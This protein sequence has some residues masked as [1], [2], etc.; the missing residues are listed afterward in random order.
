[1]NFLTAA[2]TRSSAA[3]L[4]NSGGG[5][6]RPSRA[7]VTRR[8]FLR[9]RSDP[10]ISRDNNVT[11]SLS[12][13][14]FC[15]KGSDVRKPKNLVPSALENSAGAIPATPSSGD[16]N[17]R[18]AVVGWSATTL[19]LAVGNRVLQKLALVP[20]KNYPFFL[21]QVNGIVYVGVYFSVLLMRYR[22]GLTTGEMLAIPKWPFVAIGVLE[23]FSVVS[24]MYAG[25]MLPGPAIPLLYQTFL[26]WQLVFSS[27]LLERR[28]SLNQII[29]CLFVGAG[30]V[31]AVTSGA[32]H[33][34]MLAGIGILWPALMVASSA[35]QA[36]ASIVKESIFVDAA[37]HLKGKSLDTFVVNAFGSG[38]QVLFMLLFLPILANLEGLSITGLPSYFKDGTACFLNLGG[39]S[40]GCN[41]APLLP[42]LYIASNILFNISILNLLRVS[43]AIIAS[44]AARSAVPI[45]IYVLSL[46]LP[47]LPQGVTLS[48]LFHL[49]SMILVLGLILYNLPKPR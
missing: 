44:L 24:G 25:A 23:A 14:G 10:P 2:R 32:S 1:M 34:R 26:V 6:R 27:L 13:N 42:A 45:A 43:D 47:F 49:G 16:E 5:Y 21:A 22:A 31:V 35:F 46:P 4:H 36:G 28:Y 30:V 18:L 19:L 3:S 41:G 37:A 38:F 11:C 7:I 15:N 17:R 39:N 8:T 40:I 20:M 48:P 12:S 29:G 33:T 9:F